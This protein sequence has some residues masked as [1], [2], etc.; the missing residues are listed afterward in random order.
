MAK[1]SGTALE[2]RFKQYSYYKSDEKKRQFRFMLE[3]GRS[4]IEIVR[5]L[6]MS[7]HTFNTIKAMLLSRDLSIK[8]K[9]WDL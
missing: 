2:C 6:G 9:K 3:D 1:E 7:R 4:E 8:T 5:K